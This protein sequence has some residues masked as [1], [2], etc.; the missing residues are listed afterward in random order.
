MRI[1][2]QAD[3]ELS[4]LKHAITHGWPSTIREVPSGIHPYLTFR[5]EL[6]T[7]D[8]IVLKGT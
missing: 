8:G 5:E 6:T 2:T 7:K 4:L 1:S 3:D